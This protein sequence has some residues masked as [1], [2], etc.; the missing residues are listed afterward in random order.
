MVV[1]D[2]EDDGDPE[3]MSAVD[4]AAEINRP[5]VE[6][7][8][9]EKVDAV[10]SPAE[11]ARE[12]RHGIISRQ[13]MPRSARAGSSARGG[14]PA[15]FWGEGTDM[16]LV[17]DEAARARL[18]ARRRRSRRTSPDRRFP[19]ARA[20]HRA[21]ISTPGRAVPFR[22]DRDGSDSACRLAP[23][24]STARSSLRP[25]TAIPLVRDLRSRR[26]PH[27]SAVPR[28]GNGR[29]RRAAARRQS[30]GAAHGKAAVPERGAATASPAL[31]AAWCGR[32]R[33]PRPPVAN[34]PLSPLWAAAMRRRFPD[35]A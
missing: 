15:S 19:K 5:A 8:W 11:S 12:F 2:V 17:D 3:G 20:A 21:E 1:D 35:D 7:G 24:G 33:R 4:E 34:S 25:L 28:H 32:S 29:H 30:A 23:A 6:P 26:Q 31:V 14:F 18:R 27:G 9:C 22:P 16:H 10:I 13:V